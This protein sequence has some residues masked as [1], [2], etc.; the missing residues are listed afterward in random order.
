MT[1]EKIIELENYL[2]QR[3]RDKEWREWGR[4]SE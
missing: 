4:C 3:E 1:I 2:A